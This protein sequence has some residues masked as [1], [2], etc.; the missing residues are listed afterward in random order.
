MRRSILSLLVLFCLVVKAKAQEPIA[1][2]GKEWRFKTQVPYIDDRYTSDIRMWINGDTIVNGIICK[3]LNTHISELWEDG[4][5]KQKEDYCYSDAGRFYQNGNL[6][7]DFNLKTDDLFIYN[8]NE[9]NVPGDTLRIINVCD[10]IL[11]D[12]MPRK[13]LTVAVVFYGKTLYELTDIWI[14]GIGSLTLGIFQS[15]INYSGLI[16]D[17]LECSCQG[18]ILYKKRDMHIPSVHRQFLNNNALYYDL[19][20][21]PVANPTRGVYIK[22]GRKIAVD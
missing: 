3:K 11:G 12:G 6:M 5:E 9:I 18:Q 2:E 10:T 21:R 16:I 19:T 14:E 13:C 1:V 17:F 8:D 15:R 22:D 20:G 7:F 4:K